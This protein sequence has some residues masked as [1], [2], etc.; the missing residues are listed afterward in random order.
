MT[1]WFDHMA[2]GALGMTVVLRL[3]IEFHDWWLGLPL[4]LVTYLVM[5][6]WSERRRK[7][8]DSE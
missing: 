6:W 5:L 4:G 3:G 1:H 7:E 2:A 8:E